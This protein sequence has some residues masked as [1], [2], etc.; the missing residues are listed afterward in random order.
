MSEKESGEFEAFDRTMH[1]L[2]NVSH[3]E[4]KEELEAEKADK[5]RKKRKAKSE[6]SASDRAGDGK[7]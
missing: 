6:P 2:M 3:D 4:I 1:E 7:D 5:Q